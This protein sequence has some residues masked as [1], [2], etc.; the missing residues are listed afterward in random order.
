[1]TDRALTQQEVLH[2]HLG[3]GQF[4]YRQYLNPEIAFEKFIDPKESTL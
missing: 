2:D 1:V 3:N 4:I